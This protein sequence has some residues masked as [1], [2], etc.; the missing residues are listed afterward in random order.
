MNKHLKKVKDCFYLLLAFY[1]FYK[2]DVA[3]ASAA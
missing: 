1:S 2:L 3:A